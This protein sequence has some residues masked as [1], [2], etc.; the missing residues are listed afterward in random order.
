MKKAIIFFLAIAAIY[1]IVSVNYSKNRG[2]DNYNSFYNAFINGTIESVGVKLKGVGLKV[3]DDE[4]KFVF[5]PYT[6][7]I[8][9]NNIFHYFAESGDSIYKPAYSDTL[10]LIKD[11][12]VYKY[13]FQKFE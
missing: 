7:S 11:N 1:L 3:T 12:T 2:I 4:K 8:N 13:T 9:G 10:Q 6:H 5:Y